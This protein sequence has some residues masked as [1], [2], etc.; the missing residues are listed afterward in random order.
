MEYTFVVKLLAVRGAITTT[1]NT[2]QAIADAV[3]QLINTLMDANNIYVEQILTLFFTT[4]ADLTALNPATGLRQRI[5]SLNPTWARVPL[6]CSQEPNVPGML[7]HCIRV[8]VQW[9]VPDDTSVETIQPVYLEGAASLRPDL[10][11]NG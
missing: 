4:T 9:Q 7:E 8:L 5:T 3:E 1:A 6:L 10:P 11:Y 2:P